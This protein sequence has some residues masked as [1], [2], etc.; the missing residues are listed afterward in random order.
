MPATLL[1]TDTGT[2]DDGTQYQAYT[3]SRAHILG[4]DI[5]KLAHIREPLVRAKSHAATVV[6]VTLDKE[7]GKETRTL[8]AS[9]APAGTEYRVIRKVEGLELGD[10][11]VLQVQVGDAAASAAAWAVEKVDVPINVDGR[12]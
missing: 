6:S 2:D 3:K 10:V 7:F 8:T 1:K 4:G 12:R 9:L 11:G 5:S